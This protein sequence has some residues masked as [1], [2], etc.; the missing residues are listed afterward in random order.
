MYIIFACN[1]IKPTTKEEYVKTFITVAKEMYL[2]TG[3]QERYTD[4]V[5]NYLVKKLQE[6]QEGDGGWDLDII[7]WHIF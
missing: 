5:K 1:F 2:T 3:M 6:F 7:I 4:H